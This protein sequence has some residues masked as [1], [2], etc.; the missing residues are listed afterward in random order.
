MLRCP[1]LPNWEW[2]ALIL[3]L[4]VPASVLCQIQNGQF[5]GVI[6]DPSGANVA[7]ARVLIKNLETGYELAV[8][9]NEVGTYAAQ[10]LTVGHYKL[11]VEA[12]GFKTTTTSGVE[13]NAGTVARV[14]FK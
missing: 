1:W 14:D 4:A 10:E 7:N 12:A 9:S 11:T 8:H 6:E 2:V 5:T 3:F 13:V